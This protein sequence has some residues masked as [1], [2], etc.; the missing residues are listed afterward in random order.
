MITTNTASAATN[1]STLAVML[2]LARLA[3]GRLAASR[4]TSAAPA[5]LVATFESFFLTLSSSVF[6]SALDSLPGR[7]PI[8]F[9]PQLEQKR[10][11]LGTDA[12]HFGHEGGG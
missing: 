12:W 7:A 1:M 4:S 8:N 3:R 6:T 9:V 11:S 5:T 10:A 2:E